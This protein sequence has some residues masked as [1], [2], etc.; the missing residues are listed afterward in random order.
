MTISRCQQI[1]AAAQE[2]RRFGSK[3]GP[4]SSSIALQ[5]SLKVLNRSRKKLG[6]RG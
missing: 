6:G 1:K 5:L 3:E 4:E 2:S